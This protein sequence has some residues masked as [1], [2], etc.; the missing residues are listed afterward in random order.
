MSSQNDIS[1]QMNNQGKR[2]DLT[3]ARTATRL[4]LAALFLLAGCGPTEQKKLEL[5][6]KK[7]VECL[8]KICPG[9]VEPTHDRLTEVAVKINGHWYIGPRNYFNNWGRAGFEW[10]DHKPVPA[11]MKRPPE[12]Q[13]LAEEGKGYDFSIEIFLSR[14]ANSSDP[15]SDYQKLRR[16]EQLGELRV[17]EKRQ[18][19]SGLDAWK[20]NS[21]I[22]EETWFIASNLKLPNEDPPAIACRGNI[23]EE[24][25]CTGGFLWRPDVWVG[26]RFR[27]IHGPDWPEI[28][29]E[30]NR[31]L[32]QLRQV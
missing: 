27:A 29:L 23:P 20:T 5:A 21:A 18:V 6:E 3:L 16:Y 22:G 25:T 1:F 28:Y 19:E 32:Q 26:L 12:M 9:D 13:R 8:D 2:Q 15:E 14:R 31:V 24:S 4:W 17:I 10:W 30:I 11:G 7:R